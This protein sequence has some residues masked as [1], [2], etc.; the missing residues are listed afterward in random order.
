MTPS[1]RTL[2]R[3]NN[4]RTVYKSKYILSIAGTGFGRYTIGESTGTG[5]TT[6]ETIVALTK[7]AILVPRGI[8]NKDE[9]IG[10]I[11]IVETSMASTAMRSSLIKE[12]SQEWVVPYVVA[13]VSR[14]T[15]VMIISTRTPTSLRS[16]HFTPI[17]TVNNI[18][19]IVQ[20]VAVHGRAQN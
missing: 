19:Y 2:A 7:L 8:V 5:S 11:K 3:S 10:H 1:G 9:L 20:L 17:D 4:A 14:V 12:R 18:D 6:T 16:R 15:V 13:G